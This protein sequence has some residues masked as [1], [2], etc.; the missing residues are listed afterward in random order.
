MPLESQY[1]RWSA[2]GDKLFLNDRS[3]GQAAAKVFRRDR[4]RDAGSWGWVVF[5]TPD[6]GHIRSLEVFPD[7]ESATAS[8]VREMDSL[9]ELE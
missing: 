3:T 8:L 7:H 2:R 5:D 1:W 9:V 4:G 6:G